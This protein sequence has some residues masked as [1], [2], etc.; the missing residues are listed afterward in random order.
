M[1]RGWLRGLF[2]AASC[3]PVIVGC[4]SVDSRCAT[5]PG[6]IGYCLQTT[7]GIAP[8]DAQQQIDMVIGDKRETLIAQV[9]SDASGMRMAGMTPLGQSLVQLSFDNREVASDMSLAKS[10]APA[11]L[12]ALVQLARWP[13]ERVRNGLTSGVTVEES[14]AE[15]RFFR[16]G[17]LVLRVRYTLGRAAQGDLAI[18]LPEAGVELTIVNLDLAETK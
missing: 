13:V 14:E 9:E 16:D 10:L 1:S 15:R 7:E 6:R 12:L 8:F 18:S 2:L 4:A 17:R 11:S 3:L 5:L